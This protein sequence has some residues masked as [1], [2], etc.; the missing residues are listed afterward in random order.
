MKLIIL[1]LLLSVTVCAKAQQKVFTEDE[2]KAVIVKFHPI[3]KRAS[4]D[5]KI[6]KSEIL[7]ARGGFDPIFTN[8]SA[9][10]EV[11]GLTYY[12]H[13]VNEISIPTWYGIDLYAGKERITGGRVNPEETN[14][15]ITYMGF[16]VQ[17]LQNLLMD[18]RR[19]VLLQAKNFHL[20]SEVQRRIV[21]ND[22]LQDALQTYWN[23]WEKYH[24]QKMMQAAL[25]NAERRFTLV[26]TAFQ[27]GD[28]PAIDTIEAFTQ[29]QSFQIK[30]SEAYQNL[31]GASLELSTFLWTDNGE[32]TVLPFDASPP[33]FKERKLFT[34]AE[35][36]SFAS[37]HPE[38]IQYDYQLKGLQIDKGLAFQSLLPEFKL[39]YNQ[40]GYNLS[41]TV[42]A[43]WFNNNYRLGVSFS[44]PLRLSEGRGSY[45]KAKLEIESTRLNQ[46]NK[47][48]QL[49]TRVKQFYTEWQQTETQLSLQS[50][51]LANTI[52]LQKGEEIRFN[53]GESSL[54]LLN[55]REQKTIE[56][57]QKLVELKAKAQKAAVSV[58]WSAGILAE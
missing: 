23:W 33:N 8:E 13:Q 1:F 16:S 26:K 29:V 48:V 55:A 38:L 37:S 25:S 15:S 32:P 11:G 20:L 56:A 6:A 14:G 34:L 40:T 28:R 35:V 46:A 41:K 10:K 52:A 19:A 17:P 39:K 36:L 2:L 31:V 12:D 57:E 49:Y 47:Q 44:I 22:L 9:R 58:K 7:S 5:V 18:K 30:L 21:V 51:L 45:Q 3:A 53:N 4:I 43:P 54:F 50:K 24:V 42:N 27:L